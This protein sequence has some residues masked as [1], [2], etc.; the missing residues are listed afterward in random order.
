MMSIFSS[1]EALCAEF[2]G[3]TVGFSSAP[4]MAEMKLK[5][6]LRSGSIKET[7]KK[8]KEA[9]SLPPMHG[10]AGEQ[11]KQH[12]QPRFALE[13]DGLNGFETIIPY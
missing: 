9:N 4:F 7:E 6:D 10:K 12:K 13:L 11:R 3:Q 5:G 8:N 2:L 1:F